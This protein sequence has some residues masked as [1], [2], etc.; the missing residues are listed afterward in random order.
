MW[1][2]RSLGEPL[3]GASSSLK[4]RVRD[5]KTM[6]GAAEKVLLN[7]TNGGGWFVGGD[8]KKV[9]SFLLQL[10]RFQMEG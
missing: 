10:C 1:V 9:E 5:W 2:L 8:R 7:N 6:R 4:E 3:S